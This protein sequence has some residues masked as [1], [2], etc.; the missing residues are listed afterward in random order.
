MQKCRT[1][2]CQ[3]KIGEPNE[4]NNY[5]LWCTACHMKA[6]G[7]DKESSAQRLGRQVRGFQKR[8]AQDGHRRRGGHT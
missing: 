2:D 3:T 8:V 1:P 6:R 4:F 5:D 7:W